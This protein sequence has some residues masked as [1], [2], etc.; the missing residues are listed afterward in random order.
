[1]NAIC[2]GIIV[3]DAID[4]KTIIIAKTN[5]FPFTSLEIF[6]AKISAAP[7]LFI[8]YASAPSKI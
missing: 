5:L 8:V 7:V 6:F 1:M 3:P 4:T 2:T